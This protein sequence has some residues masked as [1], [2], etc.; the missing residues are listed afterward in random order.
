MGMFDR[1]KNFGEVFKP[2]DRF[3]LT[4]LVYEGE[5][6]TVNGAAEKS[7]AGIVLRNEGG[8]KTPEKYSMLGKGFAEQARRAQRT[9]FPCVV[10]YVKIP[11]SN[12]KEVKRLEPVAVD[13]GEWF[14]GN[15]GPPLS[16]EMVAAGVASGVNEDASF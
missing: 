5:I 13:P 7:R 3:I 2:G 12:D 4:S 6:Q 1:D 15:D 9:E 10:E 16:T 14:N 11:L 8:D